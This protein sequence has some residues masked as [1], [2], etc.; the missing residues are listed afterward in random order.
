MPFPPAVA[1]AI[2]DVYAAFASEHRPRTIDACPCC[3]DKKGLDALLTVPLR[4]LTPDQLGNYA[5]SVFLTAGA[6]ADFLYFLPRIL[7]IA[8]SEDSWYPDLEILLGKL[9]LTSWSLWPKRKREAITRLFLAAFDAETRGPVRWYRTADD[10][11]CA[12]ALAHVDLDP[13]FERLLQKDAPASLLES[14]AQNIQKVLMKG[15]LWNA[16]WRGHAEEMQSVLAWIKS[17]AVERAVATRRKMRRVRS[18]PRT[19]GWR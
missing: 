9:H 16:F 1:E 14:A 17:P 18:S 5:G 19:A 11:I 4:E 12:L 6:E 13:F 3:V 8:L 2:E 10:W 15:K 7:E